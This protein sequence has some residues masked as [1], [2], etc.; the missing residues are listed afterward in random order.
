MNPYIFLLPNIGTLTHLLKRW[1]SNKS[2]NL[3]QQI[4]YT[5]FSLANV[6]EALSTHPRNSPF[7]EEEN[8]LSR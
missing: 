6:Q 7:L 3:F 8:I 5:Q 1:N 4:Q 2:N